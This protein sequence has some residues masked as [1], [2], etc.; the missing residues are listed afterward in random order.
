MR[1]VCVI[2]Q[3]SLLLWMLLCFTSFTRPPLHS[4]TQTTFSSY[5]YMFAYLVRVVVLAR[6]QRPSSLVFTLTPHTRTHTH[7]HTHNKYTQAWLSSCHINPAPKNYSRPLLQCWHRCSACCHRR[8]MWSP[9]LKKKFNSGKKNRNI[10]I[11]LPSALA[12]SLS[13]HRHSNISILFR[14][15]FVS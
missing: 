7:T 8:S 10:R 5:A 6:S 14:S 15:R 13:L 4:H 3:H 1:R 12:F 9:F 2:F 11:P